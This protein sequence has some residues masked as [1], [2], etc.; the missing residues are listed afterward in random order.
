M[1]KLYKFDLGLSKWLCICSCGDSGV[2]VDGYWK[3]DMGMA[4]VI[5]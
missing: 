3:T 1:W 2:N 5:H 4:H